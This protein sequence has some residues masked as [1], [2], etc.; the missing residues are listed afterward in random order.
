MNK[1]IFRIASLLIALSLIL[2]ACTTRPTACEDPLGCVLVGKGEPIKIAVL[3]TLTG[4]DSPYGIDALR[5]VEIALARQGELSG[6][7][8]ELVKADDLCTAEGGEQGAQQIAAD[9]AIVGVIGASCSSSSVPAAEILGKQGMTMISPSSTA[10]SLTLAG[11]YH[12]GFFRTIYNDRAQ[13]RAIAEFIFRVLGLRTMSTIHDGSVY[14]KELQAA[15][16]EDFEKL[17]GDCL[18]RIQIESGQDIS[19]KMLWVSKLKTDALYF[20]VYTVDGVNIMNQVADKGMHSVLVSSDSILSP[21]FIEKTGELSQGMYMSGPAP[22]G[23]SEDFTRE[24][25]AMYGEDP[26]AVYHLQA[27]D[28][29]LMLLTAIEKAAI[30]SSNGS[31]SIQRQAI[32]DAIRGVRGET[33]LSGVLTCSDLGDCAEPVIEIFQVQKREFVPIYP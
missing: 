13:G 19:A 21:D 20:P 24:Y 3:L 22:V 10:P 2:P 23:E 33:G 17:G 29:T 12:P 27:Y 9:P 4:P 1:P 31:L 6:H 32:R 25:R 14:S 30:P 5:G 7:R 18:G 16:C 11:E 26:I 15:A 28:A 8:V